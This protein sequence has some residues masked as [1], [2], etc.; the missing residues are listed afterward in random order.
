M[1]GQTAKT[2]R[3]TKK[4]G[5]SERGS[6]IRWV[7]G[8]LLMLLVLV[9]AG[10]FLFY[11]WFGFQDARGL[12]LASSLQRQTDNL[13]AWSVEEKDGNPVLLPAGKKE[14]EQMGGW[15]QIL[16]EDG[17][18]LLFYKGNKEKNA[19][20]FSRIQESS[21]AEGALAI[22]KTYSVDDLVEIARDPRS[23]NGSRFL[24]TVPVSGHSWMLLCYYPIPIA[25]TI[26]YYNSG[27]LPRLSPLVWLLPGF[28]IP[29]LLVLVV[30]QYLSMRR[31][32]GKIK[33][34]QNQ[35]PASRRLHFPWKAVDQALETLQS[36][37]ESSDRLR[38]ENEKLRREWIAGVS[39]D[40]KTPLS[41]VKGYAELLKTSKGLDAKDQHRY[42]QIILENAR[43]LEG[44]IENLQLAYQIDGGSLPFHPRLLDLEG[45]VRSVL[46]DILND[47]AFAQSNVEYESVVKKAEGMT[48]EKAS[49]RQKDAAAETEADDPAKE[50]AGKETEEG[51]AA[52][53]E[54]AY[55]N[56]GIWLVEGDAALLQRAI[57]N[58]TVN[59]LR[60]NPP[61]TKICVRLFREPEKI[62]LSIQDHGQGISKADC[63]HIFERYYQADSASGSSQK[64]GQGLGL[65]LAWEIVNLHHGRLTVHSDPGS[66]SEFV[67]SLPAVSD[68]SVLTN[69][70]SPKDGSRD[71]EEFP[72]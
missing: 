42:G 7:T 14:M 71:Q 15:L 53:Q 61:G 66:G 46:I 38:Q 58:L 35:K 65:S 30:W 63:A 39:H 59:A 8:L 45:L 72:E 34:I 44:R 49:S 13:A 60:H 18:S 70:E 5:R 31:M 21:W 4:A 10:V 24:S 28:F 36:Q 6:A 2:K 3:P 43:R 26:I 47:P 62:F 20:S 12:S 51:K 52:L 19:D 25:S 54:P 41:P 55:G 48:D 50:A 16:D 64:Q 57:E 40:L 29:F 33:A 1:S 68:S 67:L 23:R 32:T 56:P 17:H 11:Y 22:Q 37:L 69:P 9:M 27:H